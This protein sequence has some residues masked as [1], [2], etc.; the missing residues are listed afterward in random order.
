MHAVTLSSAR[1][2]RIFWA[3][4]AE[5]MYTI[6]HIQLFP[7]DNAARLMQLYRRYRYGPSLSALVYIL[8]PEHIIALPVNGQSPLST[9]WEDDHGRSG[10]R[11]GFSNL[12]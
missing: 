7:E 12:C 11:M 10:Y 8:Q 3:D 6:R 4:W 5:F 1:V 2:Q 9:C